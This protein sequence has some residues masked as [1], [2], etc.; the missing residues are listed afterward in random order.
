MKW[1]LLVL[2]DLLI[3]PNPVIPQSHEF[4]LG[5]QLGEPTGLNGK[6]WTGRSNAFDFTLA[7]SFEGSGRNVDASRLCMALL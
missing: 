2:I 7:W 3:A 4:G 1:T 5:I 6:L